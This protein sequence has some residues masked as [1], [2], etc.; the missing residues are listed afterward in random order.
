MAPAANDKAYGKMG[1]IEI[2]VAAPMTPAIGST[3]PDNC[4]YQKL[5]R[6]EKPSHRN[7]TETAV[8]SGKF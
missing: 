1:R 2:T 4:P 3:N 7:G 6:R 8:P 5:F